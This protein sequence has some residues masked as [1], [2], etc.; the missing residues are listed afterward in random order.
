MLSQIAYLQ[1]GDVVLDYA[2][3]R[4]SVQLL[5]DLKVKA[6]CRYIAQTTRITGKLL[7]PSETSFYHNLGIGVIPN[8][9]SY[10]TR[11]SGGYALGA[12][13][14]L[15]AQVWGEQNN[16]P[17]EGRIVA[18]DDTNVTS[19]TVPTHLQYQIGFDDKCRSWGTGPYGDNDIMQACVD[20]GRS[21]QILWYAG[22]RAWSNYALP[23]AECH[24][25]QTVKGSVAG[26]Y[27][28]N[29]VLRSFPVWLPNNNAVKEEPM[30]PYV[31]S[32]NNG[33]VGIRHESGARHVNEGE[34]TGPLKGEVVHPIPAGSNWEAWVLKE[35]AKYESDLNPQTADSS[36]GAAGQLTGVIQVSGGL[37]V[38]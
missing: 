12:V 25:M 38:S 22:A 3:F 23:I 30:Q 11:A 7:T 15:F 19:A 32:L 31:F 14:G 28:M 8:F 6:V 35:L 37:S 27:D 10:A 26:V 21:D 24:F 13:D 34:L 1:P 36:I 33:V 5:R 2:A 20:A 29:I 9:E 17:P 16:Y 18:S 4:P